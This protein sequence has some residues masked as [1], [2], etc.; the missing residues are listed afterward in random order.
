MRGSPTIDTTHMPA[1]WWTT[2]DIIVKGKAI[3][4]GLTNAE[5]KLYLPRTRW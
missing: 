4:E 2:P 5:V 3:Y 1:G